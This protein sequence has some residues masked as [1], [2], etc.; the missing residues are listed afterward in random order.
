MD[1]N[2]LRRLLRLRDES[3]WLEFKLVYRIFGADGKINEKYR[4]EL[5]KD[6]LGLANG[7]SSIIR[8]TKY[9]IVGADDKNF[10]ANGLRVLKDVDYQVPSKSEITKWVN[11]ACAPSVVGI[12]VEIIR[13]NGKNIFVV[14]IPPTFNLHETIRELNAKG[15]FS[16][17]T[18]FMRQDEHTMSASVKDGMTIQQLKNLHRDEISNPPGIILGMVIGGFIAIIFFDAGYK[19]PTMFEPS[20]LPFVRTLIMIVGLILGAEI[21]WSFRVWNTVR[22]D[23]RYLSRVEKIKLGLVILFMLSIFVLWLLF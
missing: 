12:D 18:V 8:K 20:T 14:A 2:D 22:Y 4:D 19:S 9:L 6:I 17:H 13:I 10:D 23:W 1:E 16:K 11:S 15:K 21:G 5:V 3:D 7:N